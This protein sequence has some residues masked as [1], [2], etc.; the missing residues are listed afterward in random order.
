LKTNQRYFY[1]KQ[2]KLK[3]RKAIDEVFSKGKNFSHYPLKVI[4]L[5]CNKQTVLQ[6]AV[7]VSSRNFKKAVDRN[8][9]KRLLRESYRLQK[10]SLYDYLKEHNKSMSIFFLYVGK[11]LPMYDL[12]F[13]KMGSAIKRLTNRSHENTEAHP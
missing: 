6:A 9:I 4:W 10:N 1:K 12:V 3:S 2:D 5:P 13:E 8:R 7:G 11:E